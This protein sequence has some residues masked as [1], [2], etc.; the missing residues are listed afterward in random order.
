MNI[1]IM[2]DGYIDANGTI[3]YLK[4]IL[5]SLYL[6][7]NVNIYMFFPR[8]NQR[9][10]RHYPLLF[11]KIYELFTPYK[12]NSSID[13]FSD[14]GDLH[15]VEYNCLSLKKKIKELNI[16]IIFPAMMNLG[17]N[18]PVKWVVEEFDCQHKYYPQY[19]K[20]IIRKGRDIYTSAA[21]KNADAIIVNSQAAKRDFEKFYRTSEGK[22][23]VLP[24]CATLNHEYIKESV[25]NISEKYGIKK[26]Y[27]LISNQFYWH[28]RH[29]IAFQA[30]KRVREHGYDVS[31]V[32]TGYMNEKLPVVKHVR[33]QVQNLGLGNDVLFLGV[34]PKIDQIEVMKHAISVIQPSEFEGDCSGQ[35]IDAITIGQRAIASDI[36]VI[37]EI[38]FYENIQFFKLDDSSDLASK[39]ETFINTP[40]KRPSYESLLENEKKYMENLSNALYNVIYKTIE[41]IK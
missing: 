9:R 30:L 13:L 25:S 12:K 40:F 37:K 19:F 23:N 3:D 14:F 36:D 28:K 39:M 1:G 29:D 2:A 38:S 15:S 16:D 41:E 27:F 21:F 32:C 18:M 22:I 5:R 34:I 7:R 6:R 24:F 20:Y 4:I 10:F 33:E 26:P 31:I 17:A 35:I 8:E 11:R